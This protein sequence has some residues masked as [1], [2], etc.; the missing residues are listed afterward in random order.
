MVRS[1]LTDLKAPKQS[2]LTRKRKVVVN[3][4]TGKWKCKSA[5]GLASVKPLQRTKE[6]QMKVWQCQM[7]SFSIIR[8]EKKSV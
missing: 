2:D 4:P 3:P 1:L 6:F 7:G 5:K 8:I